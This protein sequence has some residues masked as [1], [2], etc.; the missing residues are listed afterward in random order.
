[1]SFQTNEM[2][3]LINPEIKKKELDEIMK[4]I[5]TDKKSMKRHE[6]IN[7]CKDLKLKNITTKNK[8]ELIKLLESYEK[9]TD[10]E[11]IE[12]IKKCILLNENFDNEKIGVS[13]NKY[14]ELYNSICVYDLLKN[15][16]IKE[17]NIDEILN[18]SKYNCSLCNV[19]QYN[20][21]ISSKE[22]KEHKN[23]CDLCWCNYEQERNVLWEKIQDYIKNINC[24]IC[25]IE[26]KYIKQRFHFDHL[27]MFNKTDSIYDMVN[28]G[29]DIESI[30][31][32]L[33]KCHLLCISCHSVITNIENNL[34]FLRIKK[35]INNEFKNQEITE[36][37]YQLKYNEY[38]IIYKEKM[39]KVYNIL[40]N[41]LK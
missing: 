36:E 32:E 16:E 38:N 28:K 13:I 18:N 41:K 22:W 5:N 26:K 37:E 7:K 2:I 21:N 20:K 33:N 9:K 10:E 34:L 6:L 8:N 24:N 11:K 3:K 25:G 40:K 27:N 4:V 1:M 39:D 14:N 35:K 31:D 19:E 17:V 29:K 30:K 12:K 15:Q 23:I